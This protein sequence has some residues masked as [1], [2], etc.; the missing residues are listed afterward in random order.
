M[1]ID[2]QARAIEASYGLY[3]RTMSQHWRTP[4]DQHAALSTLKGHLRDAERT[5][6]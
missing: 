5:L 2:E 4:E 1:T 6:R 3:H